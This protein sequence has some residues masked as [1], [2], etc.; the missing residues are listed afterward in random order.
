[1]TSRVTIKNEENSN[2]DLFLIIGAERVT[3]HPGASFEK[4]VSTGIGVYIGETWPT[5]KPFV[6]VEEAK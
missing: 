3:L 6:Q 1:M 2:G 5:E 4:W